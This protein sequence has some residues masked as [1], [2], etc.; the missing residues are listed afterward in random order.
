MPKG[1]AGT[2]SRGHGHQAAGGDE[3]SRRF[4]FGAFGG[5]FEGSVN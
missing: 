1:A 5:S 3:G 2:A 4:R